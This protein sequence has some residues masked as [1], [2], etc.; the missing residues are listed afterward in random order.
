MLEYF[1]I[2]V[3]IAFVMMSVGFGL[4]TITWFRDYWQLRHRRYD[5]KRRSTLGFSILFAIMTLLSTVVSIG[6]F[7][8]GIEI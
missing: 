5:K 7:T 8:G 3:R 4:L 2:F 6:I 1:H